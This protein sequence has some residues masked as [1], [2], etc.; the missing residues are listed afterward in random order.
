MT[1]NQKLSEGLAVLAT[2][3][4]ISQGAGTVSTGWVAVAD[5]HQM[6]ALVD[7][8]VFGASATVDAKL[9]QAT[10]S[11]GT[12]A[13]DI[14]GKSITQLVA[15]GGNDRQALINLRPQELDTTNSFTHVRLSITV[16][17]AATL[18]SGAIIAAPRFEDASALN[19][20]GV[21]QVV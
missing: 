9:Q 12:S 11:S 2:I 18:V 6:L 17:T 16:G 1:P 10:D 20:A 14:T 4:P 8:G 3:D 5:Y 13:K 21:A 7:V 15:A 19:Q